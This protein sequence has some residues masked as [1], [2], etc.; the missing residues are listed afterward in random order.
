[1]KKVVSALCICLSLFSLTACGS[2]N[3]SNSNTNEIV[4][5]TDT[6]SVDDKSFNQGCWTGVETFAKENNK[7]YKYY[8]PTGKS[9]DEFKTAMELAIKGGAKTIVCSGFLFEVAVYDLQTK[10]PDTNFILIDGTPHDADEKDYTIG[11]NVVSIT[12]AEQEAGYLAG[13]AAVKDGYKKLGFL[14]GMALPA[15]IR[16]GYG[17]IQG[18]DAAAKELGVKDVE[19]KYN[20]TGTFDASPEVQTL[21]SAWYN[22]GTE[23]IFACGGSIGNSI[24]AA[25]SQADKK[26]IGVDVDQSVESDTVITS[27]M[28]QLQTAV[29]AQLKAIY[30]NS[31]EGGKALVLGA[32]EDAVGLPMETSKF[33]T[34][35]NDDY[36][37]VLADLKAGKITLKVNTDAE[38]ADKL[39]VEN[40]KVNLIG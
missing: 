8:K 14:G 32:K 11:S 3:S 29:E 7:T 12:F 33:T 20:Y 2:K 28:K 10:Y 13:Y 31:F 38:T 35:T 37:K 34:F 4:L 16:Y 5:V 18:A 22:A 1:M 15:V 6:G 23:A 25:A 9:T 21:A 27:A 26:V 36:A 39:G 17:F 24:M 30:D 19:V 40:V